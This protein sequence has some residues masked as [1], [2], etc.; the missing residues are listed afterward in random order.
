MQRKL[1]L[2][3][4]L[5]IQNENGGVTIRSL[6]IIKLQ[7]EKERHILLCVLEHFTNNVHELYIF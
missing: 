3:S 1:T 4:T 6:E 7:F 2:V 5:V